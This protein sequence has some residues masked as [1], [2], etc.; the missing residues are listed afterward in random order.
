[1]EIFHVSDSYV[2]ISLVEARMFLKK[3]AVQCVKVILI[4]KM[5]NMMCMCVDGT[6][7]NI[8]VVG[9]QIW[10]AWLICQ[11]LAAVLIH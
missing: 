8:F 5:Y 3:N 4:F 9:M 1:M 11:L 7:C 2:R 6:L 10:Y